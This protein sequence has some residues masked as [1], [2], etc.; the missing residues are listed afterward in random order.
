MYE[1]IIREAMQTPWALT[2]RYLAIVQ[3][4]LRFRA[5]GGQLTAEELRARIG[6]DSSR[7][8]S[9]SSGTGAI[10]VI[11]IYGVIAHRTFEASS[12]MTSS[13]EISAMLRQA[14]AD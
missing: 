6:G 14:L 4:V 1:R 8:G 3:D 9:R 11:P 10:A 13:E 2:P 5:S 7:S 12:G